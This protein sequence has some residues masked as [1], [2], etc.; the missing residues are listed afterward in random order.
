[1]FILRLGDI[2]FKKIFY[3]KGRGKRILGIKKYPECFYNKSIQD[4]FIWYLLI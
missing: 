4:I 2:P 3:R 1:M